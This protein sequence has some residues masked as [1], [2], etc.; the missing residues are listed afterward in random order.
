MAAKVS[1]A[2]KDDDTG[3]SSA[4]AGRR[5]VADGTNAVPEDR[6]HPL[7]RAL[8]KFWAPV[9]WMLEATIVLQLALGEYLEAAAIAVLLVFNAA[10]GFFQEGKAQATL[11]ALKS[12][13]AVSASVRRDGAWQT[14]TAPQRNPAAAPHRCPVEGA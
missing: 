12:Q 9:P 7:G 11:D 5:L 13:L 4:E 10:L 2:N 6:P 3:L 8:T 14:L 1:S